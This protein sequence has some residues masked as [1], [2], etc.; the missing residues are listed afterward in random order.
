[1]APSRISL[2]TP[3]GDVDGSR[4]VWLRNLSDA[5]SRLDGVEHIV[6]VDGPVDEARAA[7]LA[8]LEG[9]RV[10]ELGFDHLVGAAAAR[11]LALPATTG[12][13][14]GSVD[15]DDM[16]IAS[17]L[18]ALASALDEDETID[19]AA[20][21]LVDADE[22]LNVTGRWDHLA[23]PGR[24]KAGQVFALWE[25]PGSE[26]PLPPTAMLTRRDV[27]MSVGGW[28]GLPSAEDFGMAVAVTGSFNG[29][30]IDRDVY[31]YRK[32]PGQATRGALADRV[33][34]GRVREAAYLR[35]LARQ[36]VAQATP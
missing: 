20:G 36:R 35:G 31:F 27:L 8:E 7:R 6:A 2:I 15:D 5:I 14:V 24:Y 21:Y 4:H 26:F 11:N 19:W 32:H 34:E 12:R 9:S 23:R 18:R 22:L 10:I 29:A 25:E 30:V 13:Y 16:I 3:T 28:A 17:G 33:L 1:M